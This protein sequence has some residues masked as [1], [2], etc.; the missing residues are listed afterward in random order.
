MAATVASG[1]PR[2]EVRIWIAELDGLAGLELICARLLAP[3]WLRKAL[4]LRSPP[5]RRRRLL[6]YGALFD[7]LSCAVG[8]PLGRLSISAPLGKPFI[9]DTELRFSL[10]HAGSRAA[11][12]IAWSQEV[13]VDLEHADRS[14]NLDDVAVSAFT[15]TELAAIGDLP[16]ARR[17]SAVL[18][19][20]VRKEALV[21][22]YGHG[23]GAMDGFELSIPPSPPVVI[24]T[25]DTRPYVLGDLALDDSW[26]AAVATERPSLVTIDRWRPSARMRSA[27]VADPRSGGAVGMRA[28]APRTP[29]PARTGRA[30]RGTHAGSGA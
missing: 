24:R 2:D 12:A 9:D 7:L 18:R 29:D 11:V 17:A 16:G 4:R 26:Y 8:C 30:D 20:W 27:S 13:G 1:V 21:K 28:D 23:I 14:V 10:S 5:A 25:P 22:L 19:T 6:A 3:P 15:A